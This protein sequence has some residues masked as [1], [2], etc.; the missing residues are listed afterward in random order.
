VE[1]RH[2]HVLRRIYQADRSLADDGQEQE[3]FRLM[4]TG[5]MQKQ[6]DHPRWDRSWA[7]PDEHTIDDLAELGILR[8]QPSVD[9]NRAFVLTMKGRQEGAAVVQR[10]TAPAAVGGRAPSAN[11]VLRWLLGVADGDP[12]CLDTPARLLDRAVTE[13]VI[14]YTGREPLARRIIGLITEGYLRGDVP[15][16]DQATAEQSL[17]LTQGLELTMKAFEFRNPERL[18]QQMIF[19]PIINSQV[20]GGDI[21]SY[22]TFNDVLDRASAEIAALE[23][24]DPEVRAEAKTL[25]DRLRVKAAVAAGQAATG[26]AGTLA[27]GVLARLLGLPH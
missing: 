3:S 20:A 26:A 11:D 8:V 25:V 1:E 15:D 18:A 27:A 13:G 23:N 4:H 19:A 7:V 9:K 6:I 16:V 12:A 5:G 22:I 10:L 24:V 17:S 21:T 14:D 2:R